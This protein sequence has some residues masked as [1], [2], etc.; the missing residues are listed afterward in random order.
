VK[1]KAP[2]PAKEF[3]AYMGHEDTYRAKQHARHYPE[4]G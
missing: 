4:P 1:T 3:H 2:Q